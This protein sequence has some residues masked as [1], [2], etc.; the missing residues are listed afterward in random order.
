MNKHSAF[1]FQIPHSI[2]RYALSLV[3]LFA[4]LLPTVAL[5]LT[6]TGNV[7]F[8]G[9]LAIT[10]SL[11]KG[12]GSFAIDHPLDP[13]NKLLFHSF[14]ESPDVK[15]IY[16]GVV[17]LDGNGEAT[18]TL[19]LYFLALNRDFRYQATALDAPAPDLHL[20]KGVRKRF[21]GIFGE[22]VF[23]I[24]GGNPSQKI[25]WQVTGIRHDP[26][27]EQNPIVVEVEKGPNTLVEKGEYLIPDVYEE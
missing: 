17:T 25:S 18:I 15:N 27:I 3:V 10:G 24:A 6:I 19:P 9:D 12:S 13:E 5:S 21:F 4:I 26:Y 23:T 14:V 1:S 16:D 11:S 7:Q 22:P 8:A 2:Q 20:K